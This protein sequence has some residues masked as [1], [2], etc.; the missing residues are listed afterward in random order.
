MNT[1]Q[2]AIV[3]PYKRFDREA[4]FKIAADTAFFGE[5]VEKFMEDRTLFCDSFCAYYTDVANDT[6]WVAEVDQIVVGYLLGCAQTRLIRVGF[7]ENV[8]PLLIRNFVR[9]KYHLGHLTWTYLKGLARA[10]LFHE[11][12]SANDK[13]YPAH[14]HVNLDRAYRGMGIGR[15]LIEA[16]LSQ[17]REMGV[18]GVHLKTTSENMAACALYEKMGFRLLEVRKTSLW[19]PWLGR[20]IENRCY[21]ML[22]G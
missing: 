16:F 15:E 3:R 4:V 7:L 9:K 19:R 18:A 17:L 2:K 6:C 8:G 20:D 5:A 1:K 22:L 14:L 11:S 10:N 12:V 13:L 21:G